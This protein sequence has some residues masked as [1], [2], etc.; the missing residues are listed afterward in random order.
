MVI[1]DA[2]VDSI[3]DGDL[4]DIVFLSVEDRSGVHA[5]HCLWREF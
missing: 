2:L 5:G 3:A 4:V 1:P